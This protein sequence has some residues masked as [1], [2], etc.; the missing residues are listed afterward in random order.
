MSD[1]ICLQKCKTR[2]EAGFGWC[3]GMEARRPLGRLGVLGSL[4][5]DLVRLELCFVFSGWKIGSLNR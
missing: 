5:R 1:M 3:E 4:R 2:H